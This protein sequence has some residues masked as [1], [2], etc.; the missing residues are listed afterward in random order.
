MTYQSKRKG[1][2]AMKKPSPA[3]VREMLKMVMDLKNEGILFVP[4]PVVDNLDKSKLLLDAS[5]RLDVL[6]QET[7]NYVS[8]LKSTRG[9]PLICQDTDS[10]KVVITLENYLKW[11]EIYA[12]YPDNSVVTVPGNVIDDICAKSSITLV[13]DH[14]FHPYLLKLV[15]EY[16]RGEVDSVSL[17]VAAG[18]W[19]LDARD[20]NIVAI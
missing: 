5:R 15:A 2:T 18:R 13:S 9:I 12:V 7:S 10:D 16:Y 19:L 11:Y 17:E 8:I 6:R 20:C 4:M 3:D 1:S 14:C